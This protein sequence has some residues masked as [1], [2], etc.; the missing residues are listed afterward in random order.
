M[1]QNGIERR[2][3]LRWMALS[4]PA[5]AY[6]VGCGSRGGGAPAAVATSAAPIT[7]NTSGTQ[8]FA[9]SSTSVCKTILQ[10]LQYTSPSLVPT[11]SELPAT[12]YDVVSTTDRFDDGELCYEFNGTSS[13]A[14]AQ[15]IANFPSGNFAISFWAKSA[16]TTHMQAVAIAAGDALL[17]SIEFNNQC[18]LGVLW[19]DPPADSYV[20]KAGAVGEFTDGAWHHVLVQFDGSNVS[21]FV[22]GIPKGAVSAPALANAGDLFIGGGSA[23]AWYGALDDVRLH[24][25]A[26]DPSYIPHM[27]YGWTQRKPNVSTDP[28]LAYYPFN[29]SAKSDIG[30][31]FDGKAFN[32]T[33]TPD[34]FGNP[35]QAYAFGGTNSYIE[36]PTG[37]GPIPSEFCLAFWFQA[38]S[39][40]VMTA[41]SVTRGITPG[42]GDLNFVF[43]A[44]CAL[45]VKLDGQTSSSISIGSPGGLTDGAWHFA[46]LQLAGPTYELY[47]D[48][49][50]QGMMQNSSPL[51]TSDSIIRFGRA[52]GTSLVAENF[53][54]GSIDDA[55]VWSTINFSRFTE[56][57]ITNLMQL[58]FRP[59][60]GAGALVFKNKMWMLGGW[61]VANAL[62]TD[63]EVWSS[64]DG[65][66]WTFVCDAPWEARHM[67]GWLVFD[68]RMWVVGGDNNLGHYQN[69]VWSTADGLNW[70]QETDAVPWADRTTQY[71]VVFNNLMWLMGG[72]KINLDPALVNIGPAYNDVYSSADGKTWTLVTAHAGW[73]PRGLIIGNVVFAGKMWVIGGGTYDE[74]TY[75]NDVWNSSDGVHWTQVA[76]SAP[77]SGRQYHNIVV[78]DNKIWVIAGA[79]GLDEGGSTDVWYSTDGHTWTSLDGAPWGRRHAASVWIF[80]NALWLG[81]GSDTALYNDVWKMTYA[82]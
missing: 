26:F 79:T 5:V 18:G 27:V 80:Q 8:P 55:Q 66:N 78:F 32:V 67:A 37:V 45:S 10:F 17:A 28:L 7:T 59:R 21:A 33:A 11:K 14:T 61:N 54:S 42:S 1:K 22:D 53:W 72:Q 23:P 12:L 50:L 36:L 81:N 15:K 63:D 29:G 64:S 3:L 73:S 38:S 44:G 47:I 62:P 25:R 70:V 39:N 74:R 65:L 13:V 58:Q 49:V 75:T 41:Y 24:N 31:G 30:P 20:L 4:G 68:N 57:Q 40:K 56:P 34:R 6:L 52:S 9:C 71:T 43:N 16:N 46:F 77:W 2:E 82:D 69:D 51:L 76:A 60:D 48:G 35:N 19:G